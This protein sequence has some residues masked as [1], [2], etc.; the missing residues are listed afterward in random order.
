M[1]AATSSSLSSSSSSSLV[2]PS[3]TEVTGLPVDLSTELQEILMTV[4]SHVGKDKNIS[5]SLEGHIQCHGPRPAQMYLS[6]NRNGRVTELS[7]GDK[8]ATRQLIENFRLPFFA[9]ASLVVNLSRPSTKN[10]PADTEWGLNLIRRDLRSMEEMGGRGVVVHVGKSVD[11]KREDALNNM[12]NFTRQLIPFA[13]P[14]C[15]LLI[16]TPAGQGTELCVKFDELSGFYQSFSEEELTRLK[17][18]VDT[19]HIFA[20]GYDPLEYL[21][22]WT[23]YHPDTL[24]LIH[25]NDSKCE[26]GSRKD[27]HSLIGH[28]AGKI[29]IQRMTE[30][31]RW[32]DAR[33]IPMVIE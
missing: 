5:T 11:M 4:G 9:H 33:K 17:I 15:P 8:R 19:C 26:L 20:A 6:S 3:E 27:R 24:S 25:L 32:A 10:N 30:V 18:C 7:V 12:I 21:E 13:T 31:I 16:E 23:T 14:N 22:G 1:A 29:G 28:E 2:E